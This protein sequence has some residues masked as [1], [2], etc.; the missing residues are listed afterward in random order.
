[1]FPVRRASRAASP[2]MVV[3][4]S[5]PLTAAPASNTA[6]PLRGTAAVPLRGTASPR[7]V[8]AWHC[9]CRTAVPL[10]GTA[11]LCRF[12]AL[13]RPAVPLRGTAPA[14]P[15]CHCVALLCCAAS[16]HCSA[17]TQCLRHCV[18]CRYAA[19]NAVPRRVRG[20][21]SLRDTATRLVL[22]DLAFFRLL[23]PDPYSNWWVC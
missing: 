2:L 20:A 8:T 13:Q 9:T 7:S 11:L 21:V 4:P 17:A 19:L 22:L 3:T 6:V 5:P 10:R 15:Q 1:M 18:L 16:R 12:A 23:I 14:A